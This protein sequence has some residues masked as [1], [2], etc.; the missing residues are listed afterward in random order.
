MVVV[1][2]RLGDGREARLHGRVEGRGVLDVLFDELVA[3]V[4][5]VDLPVGLPAVV[6]ELLELVIGHVV[7]RDDLERLAERGLAD[8]RDTV[9]RAEELRPQSFAAGTEI[10]FGCAAAVQR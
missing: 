2:R 7:R 3:E 9:R 6:E 8:D 5:D 10:D 4:V 1:A